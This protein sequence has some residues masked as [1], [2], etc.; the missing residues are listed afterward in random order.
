MKF[1]KG[2]KIKAFGLD[3]SSTS[4]KVADLDLMNGQLQQAAF[5][6]SALMDKI[7]SNNMIINEERLA[8]NIQRAVLAARHI[9]T[10]YV[11]CSVPEAKSFV[12]VIQIPK[13]DQS[14]IDNS[15]PYELE[16]DVPIPTDQVYF[17][18]QIINELSDKLELVVIA[19]SKDYI[20]SLIRSLHLAKLKPVSV[21]VGSQATAKALIGPQNLAETNLIVDIGAKQT[22]FMIVDRGNAFY[23]SSI[24]SAGN[25]LTESIARNLSISVV[26]AEK[27]K[28][29]Q[30]LL[31][32]NEQGEKIRQA[33]LPILDLIVDEIKK[34][35]KF[36]EDRSQSP[37]TVNELIICGG[38]ARVSG[39]LE[40]ISARINLG[41]NKPALKVALGDP[42][43]NIK[44][45]VKTAQ[46]MK[47]EEALAYSTA[48]GL[49]L[50]GNDF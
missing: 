1:F 37:R 42:W 33:V 48:I 20:D 17:D 35:I 28:L 47:S 12:R 26:E 29:S 11:V 18:W 45:G 43:T 7:I 9:D 22:S 16:Q 21:Q 44:F 40:Y 13:M 14:E 27:L 24:P 30:G 50:I 23:T 19:S 6:D 39:V 38:S 3:I 25:A 31:T 41:S 4:I 2:S 32:E 46:P 8:E 34:V 49:A 10:K 5:S 15:I 36:F